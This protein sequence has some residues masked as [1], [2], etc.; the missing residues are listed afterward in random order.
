MAR[1]SEETVR[2]TVGRFAIIGGLASAVFM[3][4]AIAQISVGRL[5]E[6]F[7]PKVDNAV[8]LTDLWRLRPKIFQ[9]AEVT[10]EHLA[11]SCSI[12]L[13]M[14]H[15]K[16]GGRWYTDGGLLNP[17]PVWAAVELGA[18]H[19]VAL[20]A[21]PEMPRH[22]FV[23]GRDRLEVPCD[24]D[25]V[26]GGDG[27]VISIA[28]REGQEVKA[29]ETLAVVEAMKMENVLR[30]ERDG[31]VKAIKAKPGDSLAVDAVIMEFA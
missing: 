6:K 4:R 9:G 29:G 22:V 11:A 5:V 17:L 28:V 8:V 18:T 27:L 13:V 2:N 30:A 20:H 21:L 1:R 26:I 10:W 3:C 16:I 14:P 31:T 19:I 12:P 25:A 15:Y 24:C 7:P 23:D